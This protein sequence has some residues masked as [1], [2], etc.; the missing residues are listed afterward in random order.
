MRITAVRTPLRSALV[1]AVTFGLLFAATV[2]TSATVPVP[3]YEIPAGTPDVL[4]T[5]Q[6]SRRVLL[7]DGG[8]RDWDPGTDPDAVKWAFSPVGD[9]RYADLDPGVSW[10]H[11]S[12]AKVRTWRGRTYVLT[13]ASHGF[14]AVVAYPSGGRY[15]GAA[16]SPGTIRDN[17]H[18]IELLPDGRVAVAGSTGGLVRLYAAPRGRADV[19]YATYPLKDAHGLQWDPGRRVLWALGGDRL[20]ALRAGGTAGAPAL[21]AVF[22]A[23]LPT[24]HGHDLGQVA[25]DPDRLWVSSGSAVYQYVKST[26]AFVRGFPD[27]AVISRARVKAVG[28]D[29][30]TGQ[31]VSTVPERGLAETWWT[32]TVAVHR[33]A[34]TYRLA[35]GGIY[36]ARWWLP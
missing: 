35:H 14:A 26:G 15:W 23:R 28:D 36:K 29:P 21:D 32:R 22:E 6:A 11:P 1:A 7:L 30:V 10:V 5:D 18:S 17:P 33:P 13:V 16:L 34:G 20:V 25:G 8:R 2:P 4:L 24:P 31:V 12:E 3:A 9:A 19:P 27:A